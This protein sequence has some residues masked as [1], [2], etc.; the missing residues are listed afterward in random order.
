MNTVLLFT[1]IGN[2]LYIPVHE[3]PELKWRELGKHVSNI[4]Q[5]TTGEEIIASVPVYDFKK[6]NV[7]TIFTQN[8]MVK[9][10]MVADFEVDVL[11][12][13]G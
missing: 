8:G 1:N 10:S 6:E 2:Y 7:I 9:R 3:L 5:L 11:L 13:V 4:I 12:R